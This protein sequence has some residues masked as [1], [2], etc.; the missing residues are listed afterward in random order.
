MYISRIEI[1]KPAYSSKVQE[2]TMILEESSIREFII[3]Q[4][5][6]QGIIIYFIVFYIQARQS[7]VGTDP[8]LSFVVF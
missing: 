3:L 4:S 5:V 8:Y 7:L 2:V 6:I 1:T